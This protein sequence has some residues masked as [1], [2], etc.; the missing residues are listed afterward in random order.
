MHT[1]NMDVHYT[2]QSMVFLFNFYFFSYTSKFSPFI[3]LIG[4]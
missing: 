2:W 4:G 1:E 3:E